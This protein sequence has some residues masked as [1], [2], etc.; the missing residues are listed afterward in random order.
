ML[1]TSKWNPFQKIGFRFTFSF[2][3]LFIIPFPFN[4][5]PPFPFL[6]KY[7]DQLMLFLTKKVGVKILGITQELSTAPTGSGDKWYDWANNA[8]FLLV[9]LFITIVWSALDH[10]RPS[11]RIL[12][13][14]FML[15]VSYYLMSHMLSYGISKVFY[16]QFRPPGLER[17]FHTY[18]HSSPMSLMW[19]FMGYS[20]SYTVFAGV[21]EVIAGILLIFR[22]TRVLGGLATFGVMFNVFMMNMS[23]DIPVKLF[24]FQLTI[25]GLLIVLMDYQRLL[26]L[27]VFNQVTMPET[28]HQPIFQTRRSQRILAV[29]QFLIVAFLL[30]LY[31]LVSMGNLKQYGENRPKPALYGIYEVDKFIKNGKMV[32]PLLTDT[33]RWNRLLIDYPK[34]V[35]VMMMDDSYQRYV[36]K[37]D[38][39]KQEMTFST[40]KDT[41]NKYVMKFERKG[42][43]LKLS[44]IFKKDT[45]KIQFKHYPLKNFLLLNRG[46]HWV[47][48]VPYNRY[49][50]KQ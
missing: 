31:T 20:K 8:T 46:F 13:K 25:M 6:F 12:N 43:D 40:R 34:R 45:L 44:G 35:S 24:S 1:N 5:I 38:T 18:G 17:L 28:V 22:R 41:V 9:A 2:F 16:L 14:W 10:K 23:Y 4:F 32:P 3:M 30:I 15:F 48:E 11:Y 47:N 19:T 42:K 29:C 27:F 39:I 50:S 49:K 37:T 26:S 21:S 36:V 33:I 7:Y